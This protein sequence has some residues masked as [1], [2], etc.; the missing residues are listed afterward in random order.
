MGT[1]ENDAPGSFWRAD[2]D[3]AAG[4]LAAILRDVDADVLTV[5]DDNG[6]Y[7]H[8]DHIQVHR[9]GHRAGELAGTPRVFEVTMNRDQL[10]RYSEG[11]RDQAAAAGIDVP[12]VSADPEFGKPESIITASVDVSAY[13]E[14]KRLAMKA[15]A[16]QIG[17]QS[18]FLQLPDEPFH[19]VFG[20]EWFIRAG[21]GPGI[22][23]TDLL[24]DL[25]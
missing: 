9:V 5:Y 17:D 25:A 18:F 8:P 22:T 24:H 23:E 13:V 3:E 12:D 15:H 1:P 20:T 7:G 19:A 21:Q 14:Y 10:L 6:G 4:R 2:V 16:S 11:A